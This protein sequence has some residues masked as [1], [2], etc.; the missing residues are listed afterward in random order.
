MKTILIK[1]QVPD[2][3]DQKQHYAEVEIREHPSAEVIQD[4]VIGEIIEPP[5]ESE[6]KQ[7]ALEFDKETDRPEG[8]DNEDYY[9]YYQG[10]KAALKRLG[11]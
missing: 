11:L 9:G 4:P 7:M 10:A 2:D 8:V 3:F 5:T 1:A 6:I